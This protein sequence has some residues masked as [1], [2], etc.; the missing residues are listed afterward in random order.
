MYLN[1]LCNV[2]KFSLSPLLMRNRTHKIKPIQIL[3]EVSLVF[4]RVFALKVQS[5]CERDLN[6]LIYGF[7]E[8]CPLEPTERKR[9]LRI[10]Y[11]VLHHSSFLSSFYRDLQSSSLPLEWNGWHSDRVHGRGMKYKT[12]SKNMHRLVYS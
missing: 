3:I 9:N 8:N 7:F 11:V 1:E 5:I 6:V 2:L 10:I 12:K 4:E